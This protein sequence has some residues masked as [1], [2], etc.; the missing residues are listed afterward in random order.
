MA[1]IEENFV[2]IFVGNFVEL[3]A[4]ATPK[5]FTHD[6]LKVYERSRL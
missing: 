5:M 2:G 3:L 6:R 1:F 4:D